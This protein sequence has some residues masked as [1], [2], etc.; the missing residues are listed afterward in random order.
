[1]FTAV[2]VKS[3]SAC[4]AASKGLEG[5]RIL[6]SRAPSLPLPNCTMPERCAC[7]FVKHPDRRSDECRRLDD[8][9]ERSAWY[10]G[11]ERRKGRNRRSTD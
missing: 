5:H 10:A 7:K 4:C 1:M 6:T 8:T 2:S 9:F 11:S 3:T